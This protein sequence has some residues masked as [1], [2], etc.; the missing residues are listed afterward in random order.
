MDNGKKSP[1]YGMAL[2]PSTRSMTRLERP[3]LCN[4]QP[5][6]SLWP[7]ITICGW[8]GGVAL[9]SSTSSSIRSCWTAAAKPVVL[10]TVMRRCHH[11]GLRGFRGCWG[12]DWFKEISRKFWQLRSQQFDA[13][14]R[15]HFAHFV[16]ERCSP[17][18]SK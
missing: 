16:C 7:L 10:W 9:V 3:R 12:L 2:N 6:L 15:Y 1:L 18:R 4:H 8:G 17:K 14:L 5:S 11:Q 13:H